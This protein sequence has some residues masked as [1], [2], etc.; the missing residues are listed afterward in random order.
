WAYS[1]PCINNL[2]NSIFLGGISLWTTLTYYVIGYS[3]EPESLITGM[4][5]VAKWGFWISPLAYAEMGIYANEFLAPRWN[6][7]SH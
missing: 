4:V 5:E 6:K 1:I 7:V 3:P 2:K